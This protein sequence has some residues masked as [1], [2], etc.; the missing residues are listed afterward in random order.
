MLASYTAN[1][2]S[3]LVVKRIVPPPSI[4]GIQNAIDNSKS[5]C[6]PYGTHAGDYL[7]ETYPREVTN[8]EIFIPVP[9]NHADKYNSLNNGTC[10]FLIDWRN[11]YDIAKHKKEYNPDCRLIQEGRT[12][13]PIGF[14]F[15]SMLDPG[16]KCTLL[17]KEVF[18]YYI[19]QM[20]ENGKLVELWQAHI[21]SQADPGHCDSTYGDN[22]VPLPTEDDASEDG[23]AEE[24]ETTRQRRFLKGGGKKAATAGSVMT[25]LEEEEAAGEE[26]AL[27][28]VD[29]AGTFLLQVMGAVAAILVTILSHLES[30]Y[31]RHKKVVQVKRESMRQSQLLEQQ[32]LSIT[33]LGDDTVDDIKYG[34]R[35]QNYSNRETTIS[36]KHSSF[37]SGTSSTTHLS[38]DNSNYH[39]T[40]DVHDDDNE[41]D[42]QNASTQLPR[43]PSFKLKKNS[44]NENKD[45]ERVPEYSPR[46][47]EEHP[48]LDRVQK[49]LN[50]LQS[51]HDELKQQ[52]DGLKHQNDELKKQCDGL[53]YQNDLIIKHLKI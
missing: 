19:R 28:I 48:S 31:L 11:S 33:H 26:L 43:P 3:L 15:A 53:K 1:L 49:C 27:N 20:H 46:Q 38:P 45:R 21:S 52:S 44:D 30:K 40:D 37:Q 32:H 41:C 51:S 25:E 13:K 34:S 12:I 5:M 47:R 36:T 17:V 16:L 24:E 35:P 9:D 2:A 50:H 18:N 14:A 4:N 8:L 22:T 23:T 39:G 29:M 42:R 10:D 7:E 6:Y